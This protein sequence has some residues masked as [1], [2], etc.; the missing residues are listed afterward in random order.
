MG[1]AH[2]LLHQGVA[3]W[4]LLALPAAG[5]EE[6]V[7]LATVTLVAHK[8]R[9]AHTRAVLV[10]LGRGGTQWGAPA[11]WG[12]G[13]QMALGALMATPHENPQ[14]PCNSGHPDAPD[15][16]GQLKYLPGS[17]PGD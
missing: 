1:R 17:F 8:A 3:G 2:L 14:V 16:R 4:A 6:E 13:V 10:A 9:P 5:R 12:R 11:V 7:V 15:P